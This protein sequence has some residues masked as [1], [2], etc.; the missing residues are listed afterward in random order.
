MLRTFLESV[1][2]LT[3]LPVGQPVDYH[4]E[5]KSGVAAWF[6]VVGALIGLVLAIVITFFSSVDF[7]A[8]ALMAMVVR[9]LLTGGRLLSAL[10]MVISRQDATLKEACGGTPPV[11]GAA[12]V[13]VAIM[14]VAQYALFELI[15][16]NQ[17]VWWLPLIMAWAHFGP[18]MWMSSLKPLSTGGGEHTGPTADWPTAGRWMILLMLPCIAE[19]AM[20]LAP[21]AIICWRYYLKTVHGGHDAELV[22]AGIVVTETATLAAVTF[23]AVLIS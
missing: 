13:G 17:K 12:T 16:L 18:I 2:Y 23:A 9:A 15:A 21:A 4:Q 3:R 14:V 22:S 10:A 7:V 6:P 11:N 1:R 5:P 19:P 8:A 20:L